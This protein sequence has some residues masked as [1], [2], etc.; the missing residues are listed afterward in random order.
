MGEDALNPERLKGFTTAT[1]L[2]HR[3][4]TYGP[5]F[6]TEGGGSRGS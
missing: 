2:G 3:A 1:R 6:T 4:E 5:W